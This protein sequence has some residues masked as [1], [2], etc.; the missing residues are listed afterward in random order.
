MCDNFNFWQYVESVLA[1]QISHLLFSTT[2]IMQ[3]DPH[4]SQSVTFKTH[5]RT[6]LSIVISCTS[7]L[8]GRSLACLLAH[9]RA[10]SLDDI[11]I[12]KS[13]F[14]SQCKMKIYLFSSSIAKQQMK[15]DLSI[16]ELLHWKML[17][18]NENAAKKRKC[19]E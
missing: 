12:F 6:A 16:F 18:K 5:R 14:F 13:H 1:T 9:V 3:K 10:S 15:T 4:R 17:R 8:N 11:Q 19:C 7:S 2:Q